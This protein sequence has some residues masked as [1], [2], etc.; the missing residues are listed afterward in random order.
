MQCPDCKGKKL[1]GGFVNAGYGHYYGKTPCL[2]C[3]G[4]GDVPDEMADWAEKGA[5]L[6]QLRIKRKLSIFDAA[7]RLGV[8]SSDISRAERGMVDPPEWWASFL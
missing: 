7:K 1:I 5:K 6:R 3:Q 8:R 2:R 4:K